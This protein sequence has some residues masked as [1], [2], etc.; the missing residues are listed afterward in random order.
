M[1]RGL[2]DGPRTGDC[3]SPR[4]PLH[5][6]VDAS[7]IVPVSNRWRD[8]LACMQTIAKCTNGPTY[9]VIAVHDGSSREVSELLK[10]I[11]AVVAVRNGGSAGYIGACNRGAASARGDYLVFLN[12]DAAVTAGWLEALAGTFRDIPGTGLAGAKV[13]D[14]EGRL[15]EAG[16]VI[17][18]D[19]TALELREF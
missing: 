1:L 6:Y 14:S 19:G 9:E 13:V 16:S 17:W 7:I 10:Q 2:R 18:K 5:D 8:C 11:P 15:R 12:N 4:F 3:R